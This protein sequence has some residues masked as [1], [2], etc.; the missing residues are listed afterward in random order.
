MPQITTG[1][2]R[3]DLFHLHS[4]LYLIVAPWSDPS[5]QSQLDV[6]VQTNSRTFP[7]YIARSIGDR[8]DQAIE[9]VHSSGK[10]KR[11]IILC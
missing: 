11:Y 7:R 3:D 2:W 8:L 6:F 1:F 10:Y 4:D 5:S 9:H